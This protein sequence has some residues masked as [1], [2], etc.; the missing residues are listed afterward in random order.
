MLRICDANRNDD[1]CDGGADDLDPEGSPTTAPRWFADIDGDGFGNASTALK[2]CI[3][4]S[5]YVSNGLDCDDDPNDC[6]A[7]CHPGRDD[8][9][10]GVDNDCD[11]S[12]AD[13]QSDPLVGVM[14]DALEDT[15][16][17]NDD[18]AI[19]EAGVIKC[20]DRTAGDDSRV[21]ICDALDTDEDCDGG[22]DDDDP[23]EAEDRTTFFADRDGDGHGD[24]ATTVEACDEGSG[25]A[26]V[27]DD[28]DDDTTACGA[29]CFPGRGETSAAGDCGDG[30][31][32]DCDGNTDVGPMCVSGATC[33][34]DADGDD[35][36]NDKVSIDLA[37][38]LVPAGGCAAWDDGRN[39][40]G[41]WT[42]TSG[43]CDDDEDSIHPG[44]S[45]VVGNDIDEDCN[46]TLRCWVD[47]D[48]DGFARDDALEEDAPEGETCTDAINLASRKGDCEDAPLSCGAA[49]NPDAIEIC[50]NLDNDCDEIVD[51]ANTCDKTVVGVL[52][53]GS[54]CASG[55]NGSLIGLAI[56]LLA[57]ARRCSIAN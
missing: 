48:D 2:R 6:G 35:Y 13:G 19:C 39:P 45:E 32:N 10:D 14:C 12:T 7:N 41:Y 29:R 42:E 37:P 1:D 44:M 57:L 26:K 8:V 23:Q 17:C 21:E 38:G 36:G 56:V 20:K 49:C 30:Y 47:A 18:L 15:N 5:G 11:S 31:D 3:S 9:C 52:N 40:V 55:G 24:P 33:F 4:P 54:G 28:C 43:D 25:T 22:A 27:G 53:G 34:A 46:G 51:P 50:D 16:R